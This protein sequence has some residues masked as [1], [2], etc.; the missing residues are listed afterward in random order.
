MDI[1]V[2][3]RGNTYY[4]DT[5]IVTPFSSNACLISAANAR[6]GYMAKREDKKKFDRYTRIN[7]G[8]IH[9]RVHRETGLPRPKVH[10]TP[11]RRHRPPTNSHP[12]RLGGHSNYPAQQHL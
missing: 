6:P 11:L 12:G 9:P 2:E 1:V 7:L 10:Q 8:P 5:A 3:L 4:I